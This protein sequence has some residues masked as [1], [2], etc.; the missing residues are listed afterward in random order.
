ML[1][2]ETSLLAEK[3]RLVEV[4]SPVSLPRFS[5]L[6]ISV[7]KFYFSMHPRKAYVK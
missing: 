4:L 1:V 7:S 6:F 5:E 3:V 2:K